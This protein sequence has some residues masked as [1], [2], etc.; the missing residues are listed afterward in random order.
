MYWTPFITVLAV[1]G[2]GFVS[3]ELEAV[4]FRTSIALVTGAGRTTVT[5]TSSEVLVLPANE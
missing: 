4:P 1:A 5:V 2:A 3:P